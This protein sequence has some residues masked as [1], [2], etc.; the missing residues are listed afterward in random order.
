[1]GDGGGVVPLNGHC[2]LL[3]N[4]IGNARA[5]FNVTRQLSAGSINVI[6]PGFTDSGHKPSV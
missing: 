6:S 3:C 1:L 2:T 5:V 4:S